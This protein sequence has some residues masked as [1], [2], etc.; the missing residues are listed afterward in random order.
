MFK[1]EITEGNRVD[2]LTPTKTILFLS[3]SFYG[4]Y[5]SFPDSS[6]S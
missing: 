1:N 6:Y 2:K 5:L 3:L 4:L